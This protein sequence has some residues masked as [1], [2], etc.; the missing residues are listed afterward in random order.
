[1]TQHQAEMDYMNGIAEKDAHEASS[2]V[3]IAKA[4]A[5]LTS[6][7]NNA[8]SMVAIEELGKGGI[9]PQEMRK[10]SDPL[11]KSAVQYIQGGGANVFNDPPA[12]NGA[13][14]INKSVAKNPNATPESQAQVNTW[15]N[16]LANGGVQAITDAQ[17]LANVLSNLADPTMTNL[18]SQNQGGVSKI[19]D[20]ITNTQG[21][22]LIVHMQANGLAVKENGKG[23]V[24]VDKNGEVSTK[25][26][27]LWSPILNKM[28]YVNDNVGS[29]ANYARFMEI[30]GLNSVGEPSADT[31][32]AKKKVT[33]SEEKREKLMA[34]LDRD[35]TAIVENEDIPDDRK[36]VLIKRQIKIFQGLGLN[37]RGGGSYAS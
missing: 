34:R 4:R 11:I 27:N 20:H 33:I 31:D 25:T 18:Y 36:D 10:L 6:N 1:M 22:K 26:T 23:Y 12:V 13:M 30:L 8:M 5:Q 21:S 15:V 16:N 35:V 24:F 9:L 3:A 32:T 7:P 37:I 17:S 19:L 14:E 29:S 2:A 28:E